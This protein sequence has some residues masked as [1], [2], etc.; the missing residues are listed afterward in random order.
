ME[1]THEYRLEEAFVRIIMILLI[2]L[3][4]CATNFLGVPKRI[5]PQRWPLIDVVCIV[6][7]L[8]SLSPICIIELK[9]VEVLLVFL[10]IRNDE[11]VWHCSCLRKKAQL[12]QSIAN[13][14]FFR[15]N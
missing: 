10:I 12:R 13:P 9:T 8:S 6:I 11:E 15:S 14:H 3:L 5:E 2:F 1:E 4:T 7:P